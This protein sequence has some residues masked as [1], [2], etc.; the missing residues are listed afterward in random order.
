MKDKKVFISGSISIKKLN[1]EVVFSLEKIMRNELQ[2]LVGDAKG[3]DSIIQ[4]YFNKHGYYNV[5]VYSIE[6]YPRYI[7]SKEFEFK[8][9]NVPSCI[10]G[11][12]QMQSQKDIVMTDDA[13]FSLIIWDGKSKGSYANIIRSLKQDKGTKVFL[14]KIDTFLP[15]SKVNKNEVDFIYYENNGYT[16]QEV[17]DFLVGEGKFFFKSSRQLN[18]YLVDNKI[19]EKRDDVYHPLSNH[20]LFIIENYKGK[21]TG[22]KFNNRFI[23]WIVDMLT[24]SNSDY[25]QGSLL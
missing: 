3:V 13:D 18:K 5:V 24:S 21:N 22:I 6:G 10:V 7:A 25:R 19:I 14:T 9:I 20:D 17:I 2:V 16:A 11:A 8:K 15:K 12:R 4:N 23:D 1:T